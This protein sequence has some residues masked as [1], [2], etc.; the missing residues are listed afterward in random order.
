MSGGMAEIEQLK[1]RIEYLEEEK[2]NLESRLQNQTIELKY[3]LFDSEASKREK[4]YY[5]RLLDEK[6]GK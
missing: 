5:K 6:T 3:E 2:K 4:E 1:L